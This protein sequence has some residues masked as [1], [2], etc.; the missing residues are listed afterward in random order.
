MYCNQKTQLPH[1]NPGNHSGCTEWLKKWI[2]KYIDYFMSA[3]LTDRTTALQDWVWHIK[4]LP[5]ACSLGQYFKSSLKPLSYSADWWS[6]TNAI[7]VYQLSRL[8]KLST[9][10]SLYMTQPL[11]KKKC[12]PHHSR[13]CIRSI[14]EAGYKTN[15]PNMTLQKIILFHYFLYIKAF[16]TIVVQIIIFPILNTIMPFLCHTKHSDWIFGYYHKNV[17]NRISRHLKKFSWCSGPISTKSQV[18]LKRK[19][20][21]VWLITK[22]HMFCEY[23]SLKQLFLSL[24]DVKLWHF[25]F[26]DKLGPQGYS[27]P[28]T[29]NRQPFSFITYVC[30]D[31]KTLKLSHPKHITC[32]IL[33]PHFC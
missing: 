2:W 5:S 26:Y 8:Y 7:N 30:T 19:W 21:W 3:W 28:C 6:C 23:R 20:K 11:L 18:N 24:L 15:P 1:S 14:A 31:L 27:N 13:L 10:T 12:K 4:L 25:P 29:L 17:N 22:Q 16:L 9:A 33:S 32:V